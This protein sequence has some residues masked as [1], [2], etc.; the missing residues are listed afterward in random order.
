MSALTV[1]GIY[2]GVMEIHNKGKIRKV[3]IPEKLRRQL[4]LYIAKEKISHGIVFCS[5]SGRPIDRR[6]IWRDMKVLCKSSGIPEDKVFPHNLR[7]LFART[8]YSVKKDLSKLAD[9][10]GH[11]MID[12]TRIYL[13]TSSREYRKQL[14]QMNLVLKI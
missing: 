4:L 14:D 13:R 7:H 5:S 9:I 1:A 6:N 2:K 12:T 3:L 8:F 10:L 11:S